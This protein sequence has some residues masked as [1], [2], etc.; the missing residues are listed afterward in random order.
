[1]GLSLNALSYYFEQC[2]LTRE[3][4]KDCYTQVLSGSFIEIRNRYDI[5]LFARGAE[6]TEVANDIRTIDDGIRLFTRNLKLRTWITRLALE[7]FRDYSSGGVVG[8]H[9][10]GKEKFITESDAI[11]HDEM[12]FSIQELLSL[13]PHGR[14]SMIYLATDDPEFYAACHKEFGSRIFSYRRPPSTP[15]FHFQDTSRNFR[16]N[17]LAI[18]DCLL[19]SKC[20]LLIKT[21]SLLSAWSKVFNPRIE[22]ACIGRPYQGSYGDFQL[23]GHGYWPEKC[24]HPL[25]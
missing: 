18:L 25:S 4:Q 13:R 5:N 10:R 9:Y 23:A 24:L 11:S 17:S 8:V 6:K 7:F 2:N 3:Q 14:S 19:L 1:M 15:L 12:I 20:D 21:P 22:V 16:K